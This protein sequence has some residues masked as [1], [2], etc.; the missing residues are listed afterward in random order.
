MSWEKVP[1]SNLADIFSGYAFK[2]SDMSSNTGAPLIKIA[3]IHDRIVSEECDTFISRELVSSSKFD[4]FILQED[5]FLVSMTGQGSVGRIGKMQ[6]VNDIYYVNQRV[7]IVRV[8]PKRAD[9]YF[10]FLQIATDKNEQYYFNKA[11]GAGQ[12]NL[13]AIQIGELEVSVPSYETQITIRNIL[14]NYNKLIENN[15]K[16]I[17]LLEEAAQR[18]YKEWFVDLRFPGYEKTPIVDGV[19]EGWRIGELGDIAFDSGKKEKKERRDQ[20]SYYLPID[21][22]PKKSLAYIDKESI[23]LAESSLVA[24]NVNDV[25]FGAMRP[26][27]HKVVVARDKGLTRTTCFVINSIDPENWAYIVMLLFSND[28]IEYAT[29]ISVGTTM[30]YVRWSDFACMPAIIP[31]IEICSE[32]QKLVFPFINRISCLARSC[33]DLIQARDCLLPKLMSGEMEV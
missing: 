11:N 2:S 3:N 8:D 20:Y 4:R 14:K 17:K 31:P 27:F 18:L 7:A 9:P 1:L 21:F 15:Q 28:T 30:P 10:V 25:L 5:D 29:Q 23:T 24:F 22:L 16:Q 19:P 33:E 32:F 12:P 13:S 26:Y 6:H